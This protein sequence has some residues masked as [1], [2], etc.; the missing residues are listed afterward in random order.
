MEL[1]N[2]EKAI[3]YQLGMVLPMVYLGQMNYNAMQSKFEIHQPGITYIA[4][5]K[6]MHDWNAACIEEVKFGEKEVTLIC[7]DPYPLLHDGMGTEGVLWQSVINY[8]KDVYKKD[9]VLKQMEGVSPWNMLGY[10]LKSLL[11]DFENPEVM[12]M[13]NNWFGTYTA[14]K[15]V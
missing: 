11:V 14:P 1:N 4:I 8:F 6:A 10:S 3:I 15:K 12:D 13:C 9:L 5:E 7:R 2:D